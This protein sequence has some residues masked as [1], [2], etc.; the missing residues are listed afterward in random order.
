MRH[1]YTRKPSLTNYIKIF[2][3]IERLGLIKKQR[4]NARERTYLTLKCAGYNF[5]KSSEASLKILD[6]EGWTGEERLK[7][8]VEIT[9][10]LDYEGIMNNFINPSA[11]ETASLLGVGE[12]KVQSKMFDEFTEPFN[13]IMET[14]LN[15]ISEQEGTD[16]DGYALR[17]GIILSRLDMM[18]PLPLN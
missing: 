12:N 10:D 17:L 13:K 1:F 4:F 7:N 2:L 8:I 15:M 11:M 14:N 5:L 9:E 16:R 6:S 18:N 3:L